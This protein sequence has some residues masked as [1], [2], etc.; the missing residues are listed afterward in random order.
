MHCL[1]TNWETAGR[2][3]QQTRSTS[4]G[5]LLGNTPAA[6]GGDG[7]HNYQWTLAGSVAL[8]YTPG[9]T[10]SAKSGGDLWVF[11]GGALVL[12]LGGLHGPAIA[13]ASLDGLGLPTAGDFTLVCHDSVLDQ[14]C[15][16][17]DAYGC[18]G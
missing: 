6:D 14:Y 5:K 1:D 16:P 2:D 15:D 4:A 7:A 10:V 9:M 11:A 18:W 17:D 12:D 3:H 8:Q 13:A